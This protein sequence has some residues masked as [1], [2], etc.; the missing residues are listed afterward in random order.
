MF[1]LS[2]RRELVFSYARGADERYILFKATALDLN[3]IYGFVSENLCSM[4][5]LGQSH[6]T[7]CV[8]L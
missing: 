8:W 1:D 4:R 5:N 7:R 2:C 3:D 6:A